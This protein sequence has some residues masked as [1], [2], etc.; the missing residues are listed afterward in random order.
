[1]WAGVDGTIA[2]TVKD[3]SNAVVR[4]AIVKA[5]NINTGVQQQVS[6]NDVGFYS[7]P[8]LPVGRYDI[9]I[10]KAGFKLY[11][12]TGIG[13]DANGSE[14]VDAALEVGE[15]TEAIT[16]NETAVHAETRTP[17]WAR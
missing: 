11:R 15:T 4:N 13:I 6:T 10:K 16:V 7:F 5:T 12:R 14:V 9:S 8:N 1:M 2:G 3:P 17:S